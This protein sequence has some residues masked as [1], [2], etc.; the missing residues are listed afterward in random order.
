MSIL[1]EISLLDYELLQITTGEPQTKSNFSL[2]DTR[3]TLSPEITTTR[4]RKKRSMSRSFL[5]LSQVPAP[6][7][8]N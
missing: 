5:D 4:Y 2:E 8:K 7:E 1:S 3:E 6:D